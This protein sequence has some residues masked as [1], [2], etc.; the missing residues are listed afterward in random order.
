MP[1]ATTPPAFTSSMS[2]FIYSI[3]KAIEE[4]KDKRGEKKRETVRRIEWEKRNKMSPQMC[5]ALPRLPQQL[6]NHRSLLLC[7]QVTKKND[8]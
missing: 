7:P 8:D 1:W 6:V 2:F 5:Q 4:V 3:K